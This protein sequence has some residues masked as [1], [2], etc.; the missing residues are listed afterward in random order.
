MLHR[1][2][3]VTVDTRG[4]APEPTQR[5]GPHR[6]H[7]G[8]GRPAPT[9][10]AVEAGHSHD[11]VAGVIARG[12]GRSYGDAAQ[13]TGGLTLDTAGLASHRARSTRSRAPIEVGGGV[14]L[15]DLM[16][17]DHP[18]GMVRRRSRPGRAR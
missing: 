13:C 9:T 11:S 12:L 5:V 10:D 15:H 3:R 4:L 8:R 17:H 18:G 16:R 14:S 1:P 7:D 2:L 6:R